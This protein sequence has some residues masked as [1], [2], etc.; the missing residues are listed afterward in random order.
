MDN[1]L[2]LAAKALVLDSRPLALRRTLLASQLLQNSDWLSICS[3]YHPEFDWE[4]EFA[5]A[6]DKLE[7]WQLRGISMTSIFEETYP[8]NLRNIDDPPPIIFWRGQEPSNLSKYNCIAIVGSRRADPEGIELAKYFASRLVNLGL[9]VV[10]GLALGIDAAAHTGALNSRF[11]CP[12]VA[13]LGSGLNNIYPS[14]HLEL[15]AEILGKGGTLISQ[16]DPD[17]PPYPANF[18]NRNRIIAGLSKAV[19]VLQATLK[20]GSLVTARNALDQGKD[21]LVV[22]GD[23]YNPR[24]EGSNKLIQQGAILVASFDDI[25]LHLGLE[26]HFTLETSKSYENSLKLS[27]LR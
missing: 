21:V 4:T 3:S 6:L 23:I 14:K 8:S 22:P 17:T 27:T 12:T 18:L 25:A 24:F 16:F 26:S 19:I 2:V 9:P 13:V 15:A 20:S 1:S 5:K 11:C 10:S 7:L